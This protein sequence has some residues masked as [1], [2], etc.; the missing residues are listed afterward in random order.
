MLSWS[1]HTPIIPCLSITHYN[2]YTPSGCAVKL[3]VHIKL[4]P[5]LQTPPPSQERDLLTLCFIHTFIIATSALL[6]LHPNNYFEGFRYSNAYIRKRN[7]AATP[8]FDYIYTPICA[9]TSQLL[10]PVFY[11]NSAMAH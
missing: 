8:T 10:D 1:N 6:M 5:R 2:N 7:L 3:K 9:Q 11:R 4:A